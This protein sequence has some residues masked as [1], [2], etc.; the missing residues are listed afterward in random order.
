MIS[1]QTEEQHCRFISRSK[2]WWAV[3]HIA[4]TADVVRVVRR[5]PQETAMGAAIGRGALITALELP[6]ADVVQSQTTMLGNYDD[7]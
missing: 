2:Q 4:G 3:L 7:R 6:A 1:V 5:L